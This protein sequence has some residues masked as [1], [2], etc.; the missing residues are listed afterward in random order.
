MSAAAAPGR[1]LAIVASVVVAA[2]LVAALIAMGP[3]SRQRDARLD[4]RRVQD[5][6][7][8][9]Q[10]VEDHFRSHRALPPDAAALAAMPG[11][12]LSLSDPADG[13]PY[14]YAVTGERG[15]RLCAGFATDTARAADA[16]WGAGGW[17]HGSG[18]QCFERSV[19]RSVP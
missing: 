10:A 13:T 16:R 7:R 6:E 15:Y 19:P 11:W 2:T 17:N 8:I 12:G 14:A 3:P 9:G 5:L 4:A 1:W 18:R